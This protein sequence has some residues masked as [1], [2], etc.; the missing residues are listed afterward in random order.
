MARVSRRVTTYRIIG[1]K[2]VVK[3][4][5]ANLE[6]C[7][8]TFVRDVAMSR[9]RAKAALRD[10][11]GVSRLPTNVTLDWEPYSYETYSMP[12]D[13]FLEQAVVTKKGTFEN[14]T[15]ES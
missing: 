11:M 14:V 5:E 1:Y 8:E 7:A 15:L 6:P 2:V 13:R 12:L 10:A 9:K 3:G 4:L